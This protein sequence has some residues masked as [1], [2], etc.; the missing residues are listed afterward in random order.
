MI[1]GL[2]R[3]WHR[4]PEWASSD[5]RQQYEPLIAQAAA[6]WS[7]LELATVSEGLR[8]G[9]LV[10]L[11][12]D[13]LIRASADTAR[14]G[15]V[16]TPLTFA[17]GQFRSAVSRAELAQAWR[18]A[19]ATND[20]VAIGALLG[21]PACCIAHF[22]EHWRMSR[23][24]DTVLTQAT[25][26]GP[27]SANTLLRHLGVRLVPHLPCSAACEATVALG[28]GTLELGERLGIDTSALRVLLSLPVEYSAL[29]GVALIETPH[30]RL[31]A[32]TDYTADERKASRAA[33]APDAATEEQL[34]AVAVARDNGFS[35]P[36]AMALSHAPVVEAV[37]EV[38]SVLDLG[39]GDGAL[40]DRI[41]RG[42]EGTWH[43]VEIDPGRAARGRARYPHVAL[44]YGS[45]QAWARE[46][47]LSVVHDVVLLQ[48]GRLL[49]MS[50]MDAKRVRVQARRAGDRL[51][52][53][54]YGDTLKKHGGLE[55][56]CRAAGFD[57]PLG[58][59]HEEPGMAQAAELLR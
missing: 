50:A 8:P 9:A 19:W 11:S 31:W 5:A 41:S 55:A 10:Y 6:A 52:V 18:D 47:A 57:E 4:G 48:P 30:F 17:D 29:A 26:D 12:P 39:A 23:R 7:E 14:V 3:E 22:M 21:F 16:V 42:H 36:E 37:G 53:Y 32:G 33:W 43:G 1:N 58:K 20:D 56:L 28:N 59:I 24:T 35:S 49:E 54:A 27:P 45:I 13:E 25:L 40:L 46:Q 38:S 44:Q 34:A 51:V 2:P 15:L